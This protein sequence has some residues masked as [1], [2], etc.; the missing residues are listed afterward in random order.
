MIPIG[1]GN[2]SQAFDSADGMFDADPDA[3]FLGIDESIKGGYLLASGSL[4]GLD[5]RELG[6]VL[7]HALKAAIGPHHHVGWQSLR[8]IPGLEQG[9]VMTC[10]RLSGTER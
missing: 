7:F 1:V 5:D 3:R 4:F 10:P 8:A 6:I 2:G 9:I